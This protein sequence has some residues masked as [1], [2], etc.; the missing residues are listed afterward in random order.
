MRR[1]SKTLALL[2]S[3]LLYSAGIGAPRDARAENPADKAG[4]KTATKGAPG[5]T[6]GADITAA[7]AHFEQGITLYDLQRYAEA[8]KEFEAAYEA[9]RDPVFLYNIGQAH[10][11][12]GEPQKA[13]GAY[14]SYLR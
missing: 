7:R 4:A 14:R 8:V 3:A 13:I 10:R 6:S 2:G 1:P 5:A 9:K 12:A 11:M